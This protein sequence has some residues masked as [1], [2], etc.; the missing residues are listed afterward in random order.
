[1][2]MYQEQIPQEKK[3]LDSRL[4]KETMDHLWDI[5]NNSPKRNANGNLAGNISKSEYIQNKDNWF[6]ENVLKQ[7]TER[8]YFREWN[9]YYNVYIAKDTP[10]PIFTLKKLWVNYQKQYEFN[11]PHHHEG[12]NGFS[13]VVFMKIP[14][15][16]KEQ[17]A[18]PVSVNSNTPA[19]SDFQFLLGDERGYV[20]PMF[21]SLSPEDE[22]RI[23]FFPAWLNH[24]VFP[25][26][27]T[28]EERITIS[29]NILITPENVNISLLQRAHRQGIDMYCTQNGQKKE[30]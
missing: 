3:W 25:F 29:G 15:H 26:Y 4:T 7:F 28:E 21:I 5:I 9:N 30:I 8:L 19:A 16:W 2:K 23:L 24:Q 22:G 27:G 12:G 14:T 6:Y 1:M 18:L 20:H 17:Y 10:F 13:F 11:P